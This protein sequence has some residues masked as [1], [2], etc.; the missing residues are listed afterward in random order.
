MHDRGQFMYVLTSTLF[1]ISILMTVALTIPAVAYL[2][3]RQTEKTIAWRITLACVAAAYFA[4]FMLSQPSKFI[5]DSLPLLQKIQFPWRWLSVVSLLAV[6]S[7]ALTIPRV[8]EIFRSRE[9]LIA[10]PALALVFAI[11][12][13]DITQIIIPSDPIPNAKFSK[14][15]ERLSE[16]PM[17]EGWWP[18]WAKHGG[19]L[20]NARPAADG[21]RIEIWTAEGDAKIARVAAGSGSELLLPVFYYPHW[22]AS[23]N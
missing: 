16:E 14:V 7:F 3:I 18:I 23:V 10:Y 1:D 17:F 5:W 22:K 21:R 19:F 12:L 6:T 2:I 15:E 20:E 4:F 9:R 8:L 13:F 11:V